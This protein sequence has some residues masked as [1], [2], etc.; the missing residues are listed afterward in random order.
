VEGFT[1]AGVNEVRLRSLGEDTLEQVEID[2]H[3]SVDL[4]ILLNGSHMLGA[5]DF[6]LAQPD[7]I[8]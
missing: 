3:G 2:G 6:I 1:G 4:S 7:V 8:G 5:R